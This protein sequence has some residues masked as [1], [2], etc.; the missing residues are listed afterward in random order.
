[1]KPLLIGA[2]DLSPTDRK[3]GINAIMIG[4][5]FVM[6]G[7]SMVI[8]L[9]AVHYVNNLGWAAATIGIILAFRQFFQ[10]SITAIFGVLSDRIGPKPLLVAGMALRVVS[11]IALG[12]SE[13]FLPVLFAS[14]LIGLSGSMFEAPRAAALA[15][16]ATPETRQRLFASV[17]VAGGAGTA[18]GTQIGALLIRL[19]FLWVCIGGAIAFLAV[20]IVLQLMLPN[21][22]VV[23]GP[24]GASSGM[25][26][27]LHDK[28]FLLFLLLLA[29]HWFAWTQ[30][31]L[32]VT[33]AA[34]E[35]SG[36]ESAVA[37]IYLVNT[38]VT[39]GLGYLLPRYLERWWTS[40]DLL[41]YG[42]AILGIGLFLI[43]GAGNIWL[44]LV[45]ALV[46]SIGS[47]ISRPGQE[48]VTANL[49]DPRARGA[50]FGVAAWSLAVGGGLG[51]FLGGA[52][53]DLGRD[54]NPMIPWLVY[55]GVAVASS[56]GLWIMRGPLGVVRG[57]AG[58][59][60]IATVET[61]DGG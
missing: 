11:F 43:G 10:Q 57:D 7:F 20:F 22:S 1:M 3:R 33:L 41:I 53:Y 6:G 42:T 2:A 36:S 38:A 46:F 23:S 31:G 27:A 15:A 34:T 40:L 56:I 60:A 51:N 50:Y 48:T 29:G 5:F 49:S 61:S 21:F 44:V 19:D 24:S 35:I 17:G 58:K 4:Q 13:S 32:T 37:W 54:G 52:I 12:F 45:A 14:L 8:P 16:L 59:P 28:V 47:V 39:I 26:K 9:M 30:F 25:S 55:G 18:V